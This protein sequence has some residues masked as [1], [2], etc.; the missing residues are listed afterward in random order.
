MSCVEGYLSGAVCACASDVRGSRNVRLGVANPGTARYSTSII[1]QG[2]VET[3][4]LVC[5]TDWSLG[6]SGFLRR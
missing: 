6:P 2:D 5:Y 1:T 3:A 4:I